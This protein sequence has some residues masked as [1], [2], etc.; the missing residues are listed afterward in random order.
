MA[1]NNWMASEGLDFDMS[2]L[3]IKN[4][5]KITVVWGDFKGDFVSYS[6]K[7]KKLQ[8]SLGETIGLFTKLTTAPSTAQIISGE[9]VYTIEW[10]SYNYV[11]TNIG[12]GHVTLTVQEKEA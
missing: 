9:E 11:V 8:F 10:V 1:E 2:V 6:S 3:G 5:N 4:E 7:D 12:G